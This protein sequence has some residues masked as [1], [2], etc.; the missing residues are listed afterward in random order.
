M[1]AVGQ[2]EGQH[3]RRLA[4]F[5][6]QFQQQ[7]AGAAIAEVDDHVHVLGVAGRGR[8][9]ANADLDLRHALQRLALDIQQ[10]LQ[11]DEEVAGQR[12][13]RAEVADFRIAA[14][15]I[16]GQEQPRRARLDD[17]PLDV[18][19]GPRGIVGPGAGGGAVAAS[20]SRSGWSG[21]GCRREG[22]ANDLDPRVGEKY[23]H[24]D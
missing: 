6:G 10:P 13:G 3:L 15:G 1:I 2:L 21:S 22:N 4:D 8:R 9:R 20:R 5:A 12:V 19:K 24:D 7:H 16:D 18:R 17:L 23:V 11:I 14:G